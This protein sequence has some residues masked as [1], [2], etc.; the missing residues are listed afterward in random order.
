MREKKVE[1]VLLEARDA[2]L[3]SDVQQALHVVPRNVALETGAAV[4]SMHSET[5]GMI[6]LWVDVLEE[7]MEDVGLDSSI[8]GQQRR[9][10]QEFT[11]SSFKT[12]TASCP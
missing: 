6:S 8:N 1:T 7:I 2:E 9:G 12:M 10:G 4:I 11:F 5:N 3:V